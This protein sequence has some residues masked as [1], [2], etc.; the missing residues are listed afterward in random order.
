MAKGIH[1]REFA[2][3]F[4]AVTKCRDHFTEDVPPDTA[5][6]MA[7]LRESCAIAAGKAPVPI[8]K[9][10]E[11]DPFKRVDDAQVTC[12]VTNKRSFCGHC[13]K[14]HPVFTDGRLEWSSC[15]SHLDT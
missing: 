5:E 13:F 6:A 3:A 12:W 11:V 1:T 9:R 2:E 10:P 14:T 7:H 4:L 8:P 15:D